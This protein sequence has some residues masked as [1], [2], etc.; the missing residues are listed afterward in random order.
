MFVLSCTRVSNVRFIMYS[1]VKCSFYHV[2]VCQM[3]VLSCTRVLNVRFIMY[4][5]VK[6]SFYHVLVCLMFGIILL[7]VNSSALGVACKNP[8]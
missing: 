6:C 4:S 8:F 7:L 5:C 3:F 2:L 1:C